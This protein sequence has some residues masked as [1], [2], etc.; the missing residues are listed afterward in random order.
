MRFLFLS[1]QLLHGLRTRC[2][3]WLGAF[4][5][6]LLLLIARVTNV[7]AHPLGNFTINHYARLE[8]APTQ[9]QLY[10]VYDFAEIPTFQAKQ[11][12]D[13]NADGNLT[14]DERTKYLAAVLKETTS[15]L[16]LTIGGK[17]A[18]L[19]LVPN[20]AQLEFLQ[21]QGGLEIMQVRA[22][23]TTALDMNSVPVVI[24]YRDDNYRERLGWREIV[25]KPV[26]DVAITQSNVRTTE[27][28]DELRKYPEDLLSN[29]LS[30]REAS[31]TVTRNPNPTV[32][33]STESHSN[34]NS[35][36]I[37]ALVLGVIAVVSLLA[38][39]FLLRAKPPVA[40]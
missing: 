2:V 18:E 23:Y 15:N 22:R 36:L 7:A 40:R 30:D 38:A 6:V 35:I 37:V 20:S 29:P 5:V 39:F 14:Q 17:R 9:V 21:G 24:Q 16:A 26:G 1:N 32:A 28:S 8:I 13:V 31:L 10:I 27:T 12:L 34:S 4:A 33:A 25:A 3:D 19:S 11:I